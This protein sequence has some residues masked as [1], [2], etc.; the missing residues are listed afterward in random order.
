MNENAALI[1]LSQLSRIFTTDTLETH[2]VAGIDL[3]IGRGEYVSIEGPSGCGKSTLLHLLGLLDEPSA[4]EYRLA[5]VPITEID[6]EER[7][8]LRNREIGFVFQSF[9]NTVVNPASFS[10]SLGVRGKASARQCS[11]SY[12]KRR[13]RSPRTPRGKP[14]GGSGRIRL[15]R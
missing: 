11:H 5:G 15:R 8:R 6:A 4:G 13:E 10:L 12:I 9:T 3:E 1:Q 14:Y 2:A 7:A